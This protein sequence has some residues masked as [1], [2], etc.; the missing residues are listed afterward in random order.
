MDLKLKL[1]RFIFLRLYI[2]ILN[3][4]NI[5]PNYIIDEQ[6]FLQTTNHRNICNEHNSK[7]NKYHF[8]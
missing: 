6:I 8:I 2:L 5:F 1:T 7:Q 4:Q 3:K